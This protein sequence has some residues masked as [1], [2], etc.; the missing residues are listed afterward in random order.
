MKRI[1]AIL[2]LS[3]L[4]GFALQSCVDKTDE[5]F[6]LQKSAGTE[7]TPPEIIVPSGG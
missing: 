6:Q 4:V 7:I 1:L 3:F 2:M 5:E